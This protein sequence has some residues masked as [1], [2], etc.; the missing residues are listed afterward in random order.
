MIPPDIG[1]TVDGKTVEIFFWKWFI[2]RLSCL[3]W[4]WLIFKIVRVLSVAWALGSQTALVAALL[5]LRFLLPHSILQDSCKGSVTLTL[6]TFFLSSWS[7]ICLNKTVV[8]SF[9]FLLL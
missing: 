6:I 4:L 9:F 8:Y 3:H 7:L 1:P 2:L 5:F